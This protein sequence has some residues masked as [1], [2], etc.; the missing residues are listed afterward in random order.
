[1]TPERAPRTAAARRPA[2]REAVVVVADR[3]AEDKTLIAY[4]VP[5]RELPLVNI[6]ILVRT[7]DY[8]DP[9]GKEGLT[10]LTGYL[11]ARGGTKSKTAEELDVDNPG[12]SAKADRR[13]RKGAGLRPA[14][15]ASRRDLP[16]CR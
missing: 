13:E 9:E 6:S 11:L 1:M 8:L 5:D 10:E 3:D 15:G 14:P 4:V 12:N 7:G 16:E 2:V